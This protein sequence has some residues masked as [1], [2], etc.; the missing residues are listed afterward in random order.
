MKQDD[1]GVGNL[2]ILLSSATIY[3]DR[4]VLKATPK[5]NSNGGRNNG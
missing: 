3:F 4:L 1:D 2:V 5:G